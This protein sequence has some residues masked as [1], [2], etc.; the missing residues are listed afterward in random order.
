MC[1][2]AVRRWT[3]WRTRPAVAEQAREKLVLMRRR[4]LPADLQVARSLYQNWLLEL[5]RDRVRLRGAKVDPTEMR[6]R[7]W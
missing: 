6:E 3:N 5:V 1:H 4:S 2:Q 7:H